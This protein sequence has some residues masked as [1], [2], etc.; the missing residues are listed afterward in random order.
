[1]KALVQ[2]KEQ[3]F[4]LRKKGFSYKEI[5]AQIP[6]AKSSLSLWFKDLPLSK[7]DKKLLS[8][9]I[10]ENIS[11]GRIRAA[12]SIRKI[13]LEKQKIAFASAKEEFERYKDQ[14]LFHTGIA[15]YW[16][17]GSKRS[18]V[19]QFMNSDAEMVRMMLI[20]LETYAGYSRSDLGY[21]LYIHK[22]Y[23]HESCEEWWAQKL[24]VQ[25][26]NFKKTI[27]KPS[28]LGVKDRPNYK[29][30]LRIEV[31]RSSTTFRKMQFWQNLLIEH[32]QKQ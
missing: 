28:G 16:A 20:W 29:G 3:A 11:R 21:R 15:L 8:K 10:N 4:L 32:H 18:K 13:N 23:A 2:E 25:L 27:F 19:F 14:T 30:C 6:V 12:A 1:M 26:S 17:E 31:P 7:E 9:R 24:Q 5:M 22:P